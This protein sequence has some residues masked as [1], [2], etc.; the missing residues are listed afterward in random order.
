M[1]LFE[2]DWTYICL[3]FVFSD[4]TAQYGCRTVSVT[5]L[6]VEIPSTLWSLLH[7]ISHPLLIGAIASCIPTAVDWE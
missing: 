7:K 4:D 2:N 3:V 5:V 6:I 1:H